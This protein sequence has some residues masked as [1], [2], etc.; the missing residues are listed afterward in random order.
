MHRPNSV[1]GRLA[2][3]HNFAATRASNLLANIPPTRGPPLNLAR[4]RSQMLLCTAL[5]SLSSAP[6]ISRAQA[7]TPAAPPTP[8]AP[9]NQEKPPNTPAPAGESSSLVPSDSTPSHPP[10]HLTDNPHHGPITVLENTLIRVRTDRPMSTRQTKEGAALLFTLSEDVIVDNVLVIPRGASVH[11]TVVESTQPGTLTGAPEL[12]L[13][14]TDL[15]LGGKTYPLY[16]YQFKVEGTSKTKPTE[17]K[18]KGG[19]VIGAIVGGAFSGSANGETNGV[20]KAAGMATGAALGASVGTLVSAATPG[21]I[22]SLPAESQMDFYLA[23]PIAV[24]PVSAKEA[25]RL[26]QGL[27]PGGPVLYVRGD[28]PWTKNQLSPHAS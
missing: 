11:G 24:E 26:S 19:L 2:A 5:I 16:T 14:L 27:H 10:A 17:T 7:Q 20:G 21:P 25:A 4:L 28:T 3:A 8:N 6:A 12:I 23:S 1:R 18:I 15:D 9:T 13:K 22:L